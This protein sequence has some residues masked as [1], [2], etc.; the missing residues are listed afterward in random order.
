MAPSGRQSAVSPA[1]PAGARMA[2]KPRV[3]GRLSERMPGG[4]LCVRPESPLI[5]LATQ[6]TF[7]PCVSCR[8]VPGLSFDVAVRRAG[9]YPCETNRFRSRCGPESLR[10]PRGVSSEASPAPSSAAG[11]AVAAENA[12]ARPALQR[13]Y[14]QDEG[15]D[16]R[17]RLG[18]AAPK[19]MGSLIKGC[20]LSPRL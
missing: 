16:V 2:L 17:P 3:A 14:P 1:G 18:T 13:L 12:P 4:P 7:S 19:R 15:P 10:A 9:S 11:G 8:P 5:S 6:E 20:K